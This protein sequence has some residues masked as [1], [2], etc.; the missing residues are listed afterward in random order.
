MSEGSSQEGA[1]APRDPQ[2]AQWAAAPATL[3]GAQR[4]TALARSGF[5]LLLGYF[6]LQ[7]ALRCTL[8][9]A[10]ELDEAE[11]LL[12][13]QDPA[14]GYGLQPPLYSWIQTA[15]LHLFGARVWVLALVKDAMLI[16]T[17][18]GVHRLGRRATGS[19][20]LAFFAAAAVLLLPQVS[21][22]S[23]RDQSH[24]VLA[25]SLSVW[26]LLGVLNVVE[27]RTLA[28]YLELGVLIGLG[29]LA[30]YSFALV[31][32]A[33]LLAVA[34]LPALR[35]ALLRPRALLIPL[36]AL[37]IAI[38]HLSWLAVHRAEVARLLAAKLNPAAAGIPRWRGFASML[39]AAL[40]FAAPALLF[41]ACLRG[42]AAVRAPASRLQQMLLRLWLIEAV[43]LAALV[44]SGQ[45]RFFNTRW[46][47]PLLIGLPL[48]ITL[49]L[50]RRQLSP[51][52]WAS[53]RRVLIGCGAALV[54][55]MFA[56]LQ[57]SARWG[58]PT[59]L[60]RPYAALAQA[61]AV[62][63]PG[64]PLLVENYALAGNLKLQLP[65][66]TVYA[67]DLNPPAAIPAAALA[68]WE[69]QGDSAAPPAAFAAAGAIAS[70]ATAPQRLQLPY[71]RAPG[72]VLRVDAQPLQPAPGPQPTR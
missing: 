55:A 51:R 4:S 12:L 14:L 60:D 58:R 68:V 27:R 62:A 39:N 3:P 52:R 71:P 18:L 45:A 16:S 54:L 65:D 61:L 44:A 11:Q 72:F 30:K 10:V 53:G 6:A 5:G 8:P 1:S 25:T 59:R 66:R 57:L 13:N 70:T 35:P 37:A 38:P 2:D 48:W 29:C 34:S 31:A 42:R 7:F 40:Q 20:E 41:Y 56:H 17:Y 9:G 63:D 67:L 43:L 15:A 36:A 32:A 24:S 23:Q 22:E 19:P 26:A 69:T 28:A 49:D 64:A 33:L 46:M 21:W 47:Q 50:Q